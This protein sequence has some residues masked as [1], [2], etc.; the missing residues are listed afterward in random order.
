MTNLL[1]FSLT[2]YFQFGAILDNAIVNVSFHIICFLFQLTDSLTKILGMIFLGKGY[3]WP[4]KWFLW[5]SQAYILESQCRPENDV[6][7]HLLFSWKSEDIPC[8]CLS[9]RKRHLCFVCFA[10]EWTA[11][12][13]PTHLNSS[14]L[15]PVTHSSGSGKLQGSCL[16]GLPLLGAP[17]EEKQPALDCGVS[18]LT[19]DTLLGSV[20]S[21]HIPWEAS[22][23]SCSER[24]KLE[25]EVGP[26][27]PCT[28]DLLAH[29]DVIA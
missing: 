10:A 1:P 4:S 14:L 9:P 22:L 8:S 5:R 25:R 16:C 27:G 7:L 2:G 17:Q 11:L 12:A 24:F 23:L 18:V 15:T 13:F 6:T 26:G 29:A 21:M 20:G 19:T 28:R 3:V